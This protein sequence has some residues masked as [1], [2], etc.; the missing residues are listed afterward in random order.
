VMIEAQQAVIDRSSGRSMM[1]FPFDRSV[2]EFR[3]LMAGLFEEE[4]RSRQAT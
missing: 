3:R 2:G 4:A 1:T